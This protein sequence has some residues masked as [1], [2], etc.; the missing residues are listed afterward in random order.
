[1]DAVKFTEFDPPCESPLNP[2]SIYLPPAFLTLPVRPSYRVG[3]TADGIIMST[4]KFFQV[5][6]F[7]SKAF[8]GGR[9]KSIYYPNDLNNAASDAHP[10]ASA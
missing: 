2:S 5:D 8:G 3:V 6:A 9:I 1:M 7:S 4:L 10:L